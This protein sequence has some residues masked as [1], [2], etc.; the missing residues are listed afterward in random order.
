MTHCFV[1]APN[2][3]IDAAASDGAD[4]F[5]FLHAMRLG[6]QGFGD[7]NDAANFECGPQVVHAKQVNDTENRAWWSNER[8]FGLPYVPSGF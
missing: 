1:I 7:T 6:G 2:Q 8:V 3:R 4:G 5:D